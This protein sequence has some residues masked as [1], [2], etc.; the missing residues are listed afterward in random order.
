MS[1]RRFYEAIVV[2][3][4]DPEKLGRIRAT[5][6]AL[7]GAKEQLPFW[8]RPRVPF[9]SVRQEGIPSAGTP[10]VGWFFVPEIDST[11]ILDVMVKDD[12]DQGRFESLLAH[13]DV[14]YSCAGPT[15]GRPPAPVF[16]GD[17]YPRLRG[18][19]TPSGHT[20]LFDDEKE[21]ITISRTGNEQYIKW[22]ASGDI[23]I[24]ATEGTITIHGGH[25]KIDEEA[26]THLVRG[27]DLKTWLDNF[28]SAYNS[29]I[30]PTSTGPSSVPTVPG[31]NLPSSALSS[32]HQVK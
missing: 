11:V 2:R 26:D 16:Q 15:K 20:M 4:D 8:I 29:H 30:H 21:E 13:P 5:C 24:Q 12:T 1:E 18:L 19:V 10:G 32:N 14:F 23:F 28:I 27:E 7:A 17:E 9:S 25:V 22:E 6:R 3:N 31:T